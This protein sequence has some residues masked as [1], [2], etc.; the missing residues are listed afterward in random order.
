MQVSRFRVLQRLIL[1]S[2]NTINLGITMPGAHGHDSAERVEISA[3]VLVPEILHFPLHEHDWVFVVEKNSRIQELLAQTQDFIGRRAGIFAR[4][5]LEAW[6]N[7]RRFHLE[8][9]PA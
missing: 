4:L 5:M 9:Y 8:L 2:H 3:A 6:K 7:R 1:L